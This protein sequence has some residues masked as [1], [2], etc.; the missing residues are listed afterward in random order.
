M[1]EIGPPK[2]WFQ[3]DTFC[4]KILRLI[5]LIIIIIIIKTNSNHVAY[6]L[7]I[8]KIHIDNKCET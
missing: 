5:V 6:I 3:L 8:C 1:Q 2:P 7:S 4:T